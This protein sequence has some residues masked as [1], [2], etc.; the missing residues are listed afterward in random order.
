[1]RDLAAKCMDGTV[2]R[3]SQLEPLTDEEIIE[4]LTLVR[5]VGVWT[6]QMFLM[7]RLGRPD[8]LPVDDYGI[9]KTMQLA[10]GLRELPKAPWM[11][12]TAEP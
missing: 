5:G 6:A 7:F 3:R 11:R 12:E 2:P 1:M 8:V 9:R 10:Y 4:R